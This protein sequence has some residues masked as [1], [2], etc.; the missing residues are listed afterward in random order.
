MDNNNQEIKLKGPLKKIGIGALSCVALFD[1]G[2]VT[3]AIIDGQNRKKGAELGLVLEGAHLKEGNHN[4]V[5]TDQ[6][7]SYLKY[8]SIDDQKLVM[9][10]FKTAY[11][12][13]NYLNSKKIRFTLCTQNKEVSEKFDLPLVSSYSKYDVPLYVYDGDIDNDPKTA[14]ITKVQTEYMTCATIETSI[15][16]KKSALLAVY[17]HWGMTKEQIYSVSNAYAYT[18]CAHETMHAMGFAHRSSNSILY[19]YVPSPYKDFT[20]YDKEL[21]INYNKKFYNA[22]PEYVKDQAQTQNSYNY[23]TNSD[24]M[25]R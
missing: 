5:I 11:D 12:N 13:L 10:S 4:F 16:F 23:T 15:I 25:C 20:D 24:E 21:L 8:E 3:T 2:M 14:G 7:Y 6:F 9:D 17:K 18:I 22:V 19:P 1:A